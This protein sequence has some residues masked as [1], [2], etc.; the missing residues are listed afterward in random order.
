MTR[1]GERHPAHFSGDRDYCDIQYIGGHKAYPSSTDT[2][3]Y[4]YNDQVEIE[5]PQLTIPFSAMTNIENADKEKI[6]LFR[7]VMFGVV[8]AL[9]KKNHIVTVIQYRDEI[10]DHTIVVD[11]DVYIDDA[12]SLN[13]RKKLEFRNR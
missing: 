9:W 8:G 5:N 2:K 6:S 7:V 11:F 12:Q 3:T 10:D 13:Y 4:I 1:R